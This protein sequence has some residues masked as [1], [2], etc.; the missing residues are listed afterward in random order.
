MTEAVSTMHISP[1]PEPSQ[2][3]DARAK[4]LWLIEELIWWGI[5]VPIVIGVAVGITIWQDFSWLWAT[6]IGIGIVAIGTT[7]TVLAPRLRYRQWRYDIREGEVDLRHGL[8]THTRQL[9]P[10]ARIQHV[11]TRRGLLQ[12]RFGLASV[13]FYTAAGAIEIPALAVEVASDVRD[14][15]ARLANVHDDL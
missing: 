1:I 15:I 12:R 2:P 11:D 13:V 5:T 10:M 3:L 14:R 9:V 7:S 8:F 6:L 4:R